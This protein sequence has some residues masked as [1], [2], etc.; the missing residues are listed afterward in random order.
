MLVDL[1][2][3]WAVNPENPS[4]SLFEKHGTPDVRRPRC[5]FS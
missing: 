2:D 3:D 1:S 4:A 5:R